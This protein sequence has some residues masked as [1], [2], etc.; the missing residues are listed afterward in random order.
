[1]ARTPSNMTELGTPAP[2][3]SLTDVISNK[4]VDLRSH[5]G[6]IATVI[7]FI[8]NHCPYVKHVNRELSQLAKDY[9][10]KD[11]S[12]IAIN[13]NDVKNYPDDSPENMRITAI[14]ENYQFPYL[15]DETQEVAK[16]YQAACTPDF[17]IYDADLKLVYRGQLDDSRPGNQIPVTGSS[18]REALD[19]LMSNQSISTE[20][21]PSLGCNIKWKE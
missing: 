14:Q 16:A 19:C 17:F 13:S 3:F 15:F 7:M 2:Q 10:G 20:Q 9:S 11:I 18:I 6:K 8:C 21:K 5:Q 4:R 12:F 1:M